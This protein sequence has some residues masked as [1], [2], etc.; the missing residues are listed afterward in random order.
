MAKLF[1]YFKSR[2]NSNISPQ[3]DSSKARFVLLVF[4]LTIWYDDYIGEARCR[5][6]G[7]VT[8]TGIMLNGEFHGK[9]RL[10]FGKKRGWYEGGFRLG[11]Q[12]GK[13]LIATVRTLHT[14]HVL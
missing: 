3:Q 11:M 6:K 10:E 14:A 7:G 2:L 13:T 9:G 1:D 8:Y 4:L 5:Y 12:V